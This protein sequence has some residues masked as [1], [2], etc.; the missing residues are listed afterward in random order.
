MAGHKVDSSQ[1][2]SHRPAHVPRAAGAVLMVCGCAALVHCGSVDDRQVDTLDG[3]RSP[4]APPEQT[5]DPL[6]PGSE[7]PGAAPLS[8]ANGM[9]GPSE[10]P[11]NPA[12]PGAT[13]APQPSSGSAGGT[14]N[15]GGTGGAGSEVCA[16]AG[17]DVSCTAATSREGACVEAGVC[18]EYC[19]VGPSRLG[20]CLVKPG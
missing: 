5:A 13:G 10:S 20:Q 16:A 11:I 4:F 9:A 6:R 2:S 7:V 18:I 8:P 15:A 14:G 17:S 1:Q 3:G 12:P 19:T